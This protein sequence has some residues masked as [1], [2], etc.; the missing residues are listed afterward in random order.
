MLVRYLEEPV[1]TSAE[2][3]FL[4]SLNW[5][6]IRWFGWFSNLYRYYNMIKPVWSH[7]CTGVVWFWDLILILEEYG[8]YDYFFL[9]FSLNLRL[10]VY[11]VLFQDIWLYFDVLFCNIYVIIKYNYDLFKIVY[12]LKIICIVPRKS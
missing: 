6:T 7:F 10:T 3:Y 2:R 4:K 8:K 9:G 1:I 12:L 5:L 11:P